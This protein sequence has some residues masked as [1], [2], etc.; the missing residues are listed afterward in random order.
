MND[1]TDREV[2][3]ILNLQERISRRLGELQFADEVS[4][5]AIVHHLAEVVV[6]GRK[7]GGSSLQEFLSLPTDQREKLADLAVDIQTDLNEIK[8]AILDMEPSLLKLVNFLNP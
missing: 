5:G 7:L 1:T 6:L 2:K 8:E 3:D 4:E